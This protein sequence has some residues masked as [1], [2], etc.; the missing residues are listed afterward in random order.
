MKQMVVLALL[1][2]AGVG[3][4]GAEQ[5]KKFVCLVDLQVTSDQPGSCPVCG[6][7]LVPAE[8]AGLISFSCPDH[9]EIQQ[10]I[11]GLCP[12]CGKQLVS[13]NLNSRRAITYVCPMHPAVT[14]SFAGKCPRC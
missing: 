2:V 7:Q 8:L 13:E 3:T 5:E 12:K 1:L 4:T 9:R 11:P 10:S 14:S 6:A